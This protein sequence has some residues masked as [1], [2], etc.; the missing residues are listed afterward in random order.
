MKTLKL[1]LFLTLFSLSF[2]SCT[3]FEDDDSTINIE[4]ATAETGEDEVEEDG[5][6]D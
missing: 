4:H 3:D 1:L 6:K 2:A 5:S